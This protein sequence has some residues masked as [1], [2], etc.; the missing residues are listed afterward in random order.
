MDP[1]ATG[2]YSAS[3]TDGHNWYTDDGLLGHNILLSK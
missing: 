1:L 3:H 2:M